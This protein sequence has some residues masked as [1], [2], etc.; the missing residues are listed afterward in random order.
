MLQFYI[1]WEHLYIDGLH[2][3]SIT[4]VMLVVK[5]KTIALFW[6]LNSLF[7]EILPVKFYCIDPNMASLSR[8]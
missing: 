5:N 2:V 4:A 3:T 6:E 8:G 1:E 7:M